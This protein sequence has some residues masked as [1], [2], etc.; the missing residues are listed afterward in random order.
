MRT[1]PSSDYID[2]ICSLYNSSYDDRIENTAPPTAGGEDRTP[3]EDWAPGM[4]ANHKS[5]ISFQR[6]LAEQG[7]RLSTS[8]IKKILVTGG[9]WTT[10]QTRTIQEMFGHYTGSLEEGG[11]G[12]DPAAAI[13]RIADE[14]GIST[15]SVSVSLPYMDVVY[16]LPEPSANAKRCRRWKER[17]VTKLRN[18]STGE[19]CQPEEDWS[20]WLWKKVIEH[21]GKTF[22]TSGR[23]QRPGVAFSY[24]VS[25]SGGAGGRHYEGAEVE[26]YDNEL[27]VTTNPNSSDTRKLKNSISRSTVELGYKRARE[28]DGSVPGP[29]ALGIPGAGSYVFIL[30][31]EFGV[32]KEQEA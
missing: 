22:A 16:N 29:K 9:L 3:G 28:M 14:L 7:I 10:Q 5:L 6:E 20:L 27:L 1:N 21:E 30:L 19:V 13:K 32:I 11:E 26:G 23:G 31:R 12:E 2:F 15:V 4:T 17:K 8:K 24:T 25:R 18:E